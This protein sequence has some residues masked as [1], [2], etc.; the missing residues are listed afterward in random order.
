MIKRKMTVVRRLPGR[1]LLLALVLLSPAVHGQNITK[2]QDEDG[3]W[4]YGDFASEA[5]S[6]KSTITEIDQR[7]N[8]VRETDAPPTKEELKEKAAE[9]QREKEEAKRKAE[10]EEQEQRLLRTYDSARS[11]INAREERVAAL[12][13]E[14]ESYELFRQDLVDEKS[15]LEKSNGNAKRID[16][17]EK[18]IKQYDD[19]IQRLQDERRETIKEYNSDLERYRELTGEKDKATSTGE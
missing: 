10:K 18:Q 9:K 3:N 15:H 14:M 6:T 4:H 11:I 13:K 5:C 12:D 19:A 8:K 7:G 16:G 1:R 17:I 2:C